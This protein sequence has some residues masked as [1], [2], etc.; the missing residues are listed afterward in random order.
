[1]KASKRDI[2]RRFTHYPPIDDAKRSQHTIV[3]DAC[4]QLAV[5]LEETLPEGREK[6]LALTKLEEVMFWANSAVA[7]PPEETA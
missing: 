4:Y 6:A 5:T 1:M 3:R 2:I 7:R